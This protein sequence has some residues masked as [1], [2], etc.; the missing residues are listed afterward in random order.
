MKPKI[1]LYIATTIDGFIADKDGSVKFLDKLS[2]CGDDFGYKKFFD[3][4]GGIIMGHTTYKQFA[5]EADY[6]K[7]YEGKPIYV[8]SRKERKP[9]KSVI[10]VNENIREFS[11]KL[12]KDTWLVGG[13][14][15]IG[16]FL[17]YD[18]VDEMILT[19]VPELLGE[20][21]SLFGS[22]STPMNLSLRSTN[23]YDM[24][25]VELHYVRK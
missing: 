4:I 20:G 12:K 22:S 21:I 23:T 7:V 15:I 19:I 25:V 6:S 8:F 18:L 13:A 10:I 9:D 16:E 3:P 24:G 2:D 14:Q 11:K 17:K 1:K 5:G